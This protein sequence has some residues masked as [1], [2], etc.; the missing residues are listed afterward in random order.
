[1]AG[2]EAGPRS[3]RFGD[4]QQTRRQILREAEN[5]LRRFGPAKLTVTDIAAS[6]GMSHSNLYRFFPN[7]AAIYGALAQVWFRD[8]E[9]ALEQIA[10]RPGDAAERLRDYVV[11]MLRLKRQKAAADRELFAAYLEATEECR[12]VVASH[13]GR[14][15]DALRRIV[16][17]GMA[18]GHFAAADVAATAAAIETATWRF[19]HPALI[20][21]HL[22][23]PEEANAEQ[24]VALL[25]RGLRPAP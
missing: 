9:T 18:A 21:Q 1:M 24:V 3:R 20:L 4:A 15:H 17:D 25:L 16:A 12:D 19:R 5:L 23:A 2:A 22:D 10:T 8:V 11:T 13:V 6:C 14:L 7:K